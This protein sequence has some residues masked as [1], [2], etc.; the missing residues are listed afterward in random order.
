MV[1]D[2]ARTSKRASVAAAV[3]MSLWGLSPAAAHAQ[4]GRFHVYS[5]RTPTGEAAPVDGWTG[6]L[7]SGNSGDDHV[8]SSCGAHGALTA[9]LGDQEPHFAGDDSATWTFAAPPWSRVV[10]ASLWR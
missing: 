2:F 9:A 4:S 5:C 7:G 6:T 10:G 1:R 8:L 3:C